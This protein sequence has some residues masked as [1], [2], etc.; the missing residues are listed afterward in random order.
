MEEVIFNKEEMVDFP[1]AGKV[2]WLFTIQ[3]FETEIQNDQF[4][5]KKKKKISGKAWRSTGH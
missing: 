2:N 5:Q 1:K 4:P 3:K